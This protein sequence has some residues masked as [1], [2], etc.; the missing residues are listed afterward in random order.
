VHQ[1]FLVN[2]SRGSLDIT[3]KSKEGITVILTAFCFSAMAI[4]TRKVIS[5][6]MTDG[7]K[8]GMRLSRR[9]S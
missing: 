4:L 6:V 3:S 5:I 9:I 7:R 1:I 2:I 8:N